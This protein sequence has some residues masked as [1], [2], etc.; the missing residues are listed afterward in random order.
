MKG[1]AAIMKIDAKKMTAQV[2]GWLIAALIV[3]LGVV[4]ML[5]C[6]GIYTAKDSSPYSSE[7]IAQRFDSIAFLVYL[8]LSAVLFGVILRIVLPEEKRRPKAIRDNRINMQGIHNMLCRFPP[9]GGSYCQ[10]LARAN[11]LKPV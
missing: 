1:L 9:C 4:L 7:I 6:W 10:N 8:T 5:S 2:T 11:I 3:I